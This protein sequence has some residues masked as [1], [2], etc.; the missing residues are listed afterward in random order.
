MKSA[1]P[2]LIFI[3]FF[4]ILITACSTDLSYESKE[5]IANGDVVSVHG[6]IIN[7]YLCNNDKTSKI[8]ILEIS[9]TPNN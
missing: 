2:I 6:Q 4:C 1:K 9:A 8:S 5:A 3:T 7:Y